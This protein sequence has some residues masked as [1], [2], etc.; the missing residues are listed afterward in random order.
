MH[1]FSTQT[2][3]KVVLKNYAHNLLVGNNLYV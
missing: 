1:K 2:S 3:V